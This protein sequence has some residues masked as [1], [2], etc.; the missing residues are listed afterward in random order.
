MKKLIIGSF[1]AVISLTG[2]SQNQGASL[3]G[4]VESTFQYLNQDSLI[5]A[6]QP[7]SKGLI[8][9]YMNVFYTNK[10]FKAG[11]RIESYLPR[12]QGYPNRFDG[13]GIGMRYIGYSND[14]VDVTL[15]SFYEQ[16]GSGMSLRTYEDRAL[17]YDNMLDGARVILR[18][19]KGVTLKGVYGLQRYSF[20]SGKI[21]HSA[22]IVRGLDGEVNLNSVFKKLEG[23]KLD[24]TLGG[25]F[26]SKYQADD[27]IQYILP[28]NTG[29]YGGRAKLRYAKFTLGG[30]YV[31]KGQDPSTDNGYI[32]NYGHAALVNF[33]YS[34]KGLGIVLSAKS[35]DNMS[36]R[37]DREKELTDLFINYLPAMN[38][39]HTY[40]LVSSI[41]PYATQ[42]TGEIAYQAEILY[43]LKRKSKLGGKY[44]TSINANFSTAYR[45][46]QRTGNIDPADSTGVAYEGRIF[47]QSDSLLWRDFNI[48]IYRKFTKQF[49][50][51]LSYY[52]ISLN[53]DVAK[54]TQDAHGII[55]SHI[56][57]VE[58]GYKI[59]K[60]HSL[61]LEL[62]GL[63]IKDDEHGNINDKG[64][65]ATILLEYNV[66]PHWFFSIMDQYNYGN[67]S[68]EL[69]LH[70]AYGSFGYIKDATR[71]SIGYGR[72]REG[73]F[74]V[75]GVCRYVPA[76]NGLTLSFT[77]SF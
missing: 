77:H 44:G 49:N 69:Q 76:S 5:D 71:I 15:G 36:Y 50:A 16:F 59:N 39:T 25:S 35:V 42:P 38:K 75:G 2:F 40:N 55:Q 10:G 60:K 53:N 45:P 24:V 47:D 72:Q 66:S 52:N 17:G 46:L 9:T 57:V 12:I 37:S 63:F 70:Y 7:D 43:T 33:G 34:Q 8:N 56:G 18:P 54:V 73:L 19:Y 21:V 4:N 29:V 48:N 67:P 31:I 65:W 14:F 62:Q 41:Y 74:C 13:T 61:R 27:N 32:Y 28:E 58:L 1:M 51:R 30:E 68:D 3:T 26:V 6:Q 22:G 64:N 20:E 11:M 23:K